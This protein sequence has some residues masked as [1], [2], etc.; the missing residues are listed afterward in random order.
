[1]SDN[2][3][4]PHSTYETRNFST[5]AIRLIIFHVLTKKDKKIW[6]WEN[7]FDGR[8]KKTIFLLLIQTE[9]NKCI[10]KI[11]IGLRGCRT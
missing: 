5:F 2:H 8:K 3:T 7:A 6:C 11:L 1:M 4:N 10:I 9:E